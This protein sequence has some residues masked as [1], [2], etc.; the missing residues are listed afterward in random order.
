MNKLEG[1]DKD[2]LVE[3]M[4]PQFHALK[5]ASTGRQI[6]AIDRL[7]TA[8]GSP[9]KGEDGAP[10]DSSAPTPSLTMEPNS[11]SS[12]HPPSTTPSAAGELVSD[13]GKIVTNDEPE[14]PEVHAGEA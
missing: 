13:A 3:E 10:V 8:A 6:A 1:T 2:H 9:V 4:K 5:K 14:L 7:I 11:P 12:S